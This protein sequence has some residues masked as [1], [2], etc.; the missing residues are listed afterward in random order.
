MR[1]TSPRTVGFLKDGKTI[2]WSP[3]NYSKEYS[4]FQLPCGKCLECRLEYARQWAIRCVHEAQMH[5]ENC[6]I[7]LTYDNENL[8]PKLDY[9]DFQ[10]FM[11]RLRFANANK[12]IGCFV[13][14]EY[15]EK[16]KRPH[17][18]AILFNWQPQDAKI[19]RTTDRGDKVFTSEHLTTLWGKGLCEFGSVS[20]HSA[21]YCARYSTK[22]LTHGKDGE[23]DFEPISKKSSKYAIGKK[24]LEQY[25]TDVFNVGK[26]I[27]KDGSSCTIP[28]YYEKW[29]KKNHPEAWRKYNEG[30]KLKAITESQA[31]TDAER[32]RYEKENARRLE[33][34][35][36]T[37]SP[38]ENE[39]RNTIT[40]TKV[41]MLR[42]NLKL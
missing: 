4:T 5:E 23:H 40:K 11:K 9:E 42:K 31:R 28:R 10:K 29:F 1:C 27:L 22:K 6:F 36:L 17:W 33:E 39:R 24:W 2:S 37:F 8:K 7:T 32:K 20:I 25:W 30:L 35:K 15:G 18:H 14:G 41:E 19:L 38:S 16:N 12:K 26:I 34:G 3:K 21:G 13:T